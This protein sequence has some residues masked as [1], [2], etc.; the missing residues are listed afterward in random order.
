[1]KLDIREDALYQNDITTESIL[2]LSL[3]RSCAIQ[4]CGTPMG[5]GYEG[6]GE[7]YFFSEACSNCRR[8]DRLA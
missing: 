5:T 2:N 1:M 7:R 8:S 4:I 6:G 3:E